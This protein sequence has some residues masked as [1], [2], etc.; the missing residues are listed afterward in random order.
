MISDRVKPGEMK[1]LASL[2]PQLRVL[3]GSSGVGTSISPWST[4]T[5]RRRLIFMSTSQESSDAFR[6]VGLLLH[7]ILADCNLTRFK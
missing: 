4:R 3:G 5:S 1:P 7:G 2:S 6:R